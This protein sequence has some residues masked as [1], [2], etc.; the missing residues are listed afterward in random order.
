MHCAGACEAAIAAVDWDL[1]V[2]DEAH[3]LR[4]AYRESSRLGQAIRRATSERRRFSSRLLLCKTP[5]RN[6]TG[7]P[8]S[9][10]TASSATS[11]LSARNT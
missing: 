7:Y 4:N 1:V 9:L 6:S 3:K 2:M 11:L 10:T 8:R 5:S